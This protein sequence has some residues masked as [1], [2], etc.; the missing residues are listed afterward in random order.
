MTNEAALQIIEHYFAGKATREQYETALAFFENDPTSRAR[1]T[2]LYGALLEPGGISCEVCQSLMPVYLDPLARTQLGPTEQQKFLQHVTE[3]VNCAEEYLAL[4]SFEAP[5]LPQEA[6]VPRFK[7]PKPVGL[8]PNNSPETKKS[9]GWPKGLR[10][11]LKK[12]V[13]TGQTLQFELQFEAADENLTEDEAARQAELMSNQLDLFSSQIG[14]NLAVGM[15]VEAI[16]LSDNAEYCQIYISLG[17]P[18]LAN[19]SIGHRVELSYSGQSQAELSDPSGLALKEATAPYSTSKYQEALTNQ[20]GQAIFEA[21]PLAALSGL[22][23]EV[24]VRL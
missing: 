4:S 20:Q 1:L 21:V 17:G 13:D 11:L 12:V 10:P 19:H 22:K 18:G 16:R 9:L 14:T 23:L 7:V 15:Q 24:T 6:V 2:E 5:P 8:T 3:C